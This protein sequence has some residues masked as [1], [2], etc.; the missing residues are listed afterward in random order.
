MNKTLFTWEITKN[1]DANVYKI[2]ENNKKL[3]DIIN[4]VIELLPSHQKVGERPS[5]VKIAMVQKL[6]LL[7]IMV[8]NLEKELQERNKF[9]EI[10]KGKEIR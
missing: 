9:K 5:L 1:I 3:R 2:N 4:M 10:K 6:E 8:K 7:K